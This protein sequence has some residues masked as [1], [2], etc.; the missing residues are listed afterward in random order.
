M[1]QKIDHI[2]IAVHSINESLPLYTEVFGMKLEAIET[3]ENQGVKVA[4]L[5][6]GNTRLELLEALSED[7]PIAGYLAKRGEGIHH[8]ALGVEGIENRIEELKEQ[9]IT[10]IDDT[11]RI[12]AHEAKVAFIH[13]KSTASVLF[14][15]C[16]HNNKGE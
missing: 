2:G 15:L 10:M 5:F 8:I 11:S 16:E 1:I 7:S 9:G 14:E 6:A 3:V 13:P 4:F 12:G